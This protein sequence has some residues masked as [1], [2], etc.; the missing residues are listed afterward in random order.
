MTGALPTLVAASFGWFLASP[1]VYLYSH[2]CL[3]TSAV[4]T[5]QPGSVTVIP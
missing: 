4:R 1:W 5:M 2:S 3:R